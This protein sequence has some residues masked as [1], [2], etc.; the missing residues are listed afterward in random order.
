[1]DLSKPPDQELVRDY[2]SN[3]IKRLVSNE[4]S[5]DSETDLNQ[6]SK[7]TIDSLELIA[8]KLKK[9]IALNRSRNSTFNQSIF[10]DYNSESSLCMRCGGTGFLPQYG[11]VEGGVCFS[12]GGSGHD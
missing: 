4:Q 1:M 3:R 12:C 7:N 9:Q 10:H 6:L 2:I 5:K 8:N 11:H